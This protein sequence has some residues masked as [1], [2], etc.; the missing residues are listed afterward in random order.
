MKDPG[1]VSQ[2]LTFSVW[3]KKYS[4]YLTSWLLD[5]EG[6]NIQLYKE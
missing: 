1:P 5:F 3:L 2:N 6:E 4:I